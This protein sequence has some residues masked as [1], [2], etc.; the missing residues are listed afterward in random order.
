MDSFQLDIVT[1][2]LMIVGERVHTYVCM[3]I[4]VFNVCS[5]SWVGIYVLTI[6]ITVQWGRDIDFPLWRVAD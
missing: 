1:V 4:I 2:V 5:E 3:Y 6:L